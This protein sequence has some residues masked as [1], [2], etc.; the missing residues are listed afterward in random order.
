M[1]L[2]AGTRVALAI[3]ALPLALI[4]LAVTLVVVAATTT[5]GA[6][7]SLAAADQLA[8]GRLALGEVSGSLVGGL[9]L[10]HVVYDSPSLR[11]EV[12]RVVI[13][14]VPSA[15]L[16]RR[17][18]FAVLSVEGARVTLRE[19]A[20]DDSASDD[21]TMLPSIPDWLS[22]RSLR[23][24][25]AE[26]VGIGAV[27]ELDARI[28]GSRIE[29]ARLEARSGTTRIQASGSLSARSGEFSANFETA[30]VVAIDGDE[31]Q[32]GNDAGSELRVD[33]A[34]DLVLAA[35]GR[36]LAATLA[37]RRFAV[38]ASGVQWSSERGEVAATLADDVVTVEELSAE[39]LGGA[40][41]MHGAASTSALSGYA[42]V[43]YERLDPS[44]ASAQLTGRVDGRFVAAF[45]LDPMLVVGLAGDTSG[46]LR[47][48]AFDADLRG[49]LLGDS[50]YLDRGDVRLGDGRMALHGA[51]E[52]DRVAVTFDAELPDLAAWYPEASGSA[53]IS[54]AATGARADPVL[55]A[56]VR[57]ENA[58]FGALPPLTSLAIDVAGT[59]G[60]HE[61]SAA[62]ENA[63]AALTLRVR[64]GWRD[65]R[66][67]GTVH[68]AT[69]SGERIG[70]W[71]TDTVAD[72]SWQGAHAALRS[73]C[74]AGPSAA[75]LCVDFADDTLGVTGNEI[76]AALAAAAFGTD[77]QV[78]G[79]ADLEVMVGFEPTLHG[80]FMLAQPVLG[81]Q[82]PPGHEPSATRF[83]AV[84]GLSMAGT[85][86]EEAL[87]VTM[88]AA[89]AETGGSI[90]GRMTLT[91]PTADGELDAR[92]DA[93]IDDLA[94]FDVL[95]DEIE[96]PQGSVSLDFGAT[97]TPR[98][99][100]VDGKVLVESASAALPDLGIEISDVSLAARADS[101]NGFA[102]DA[103]L[104][105]RGCL[106]V[107]GTLELA[108]ETTGW[109][110][111]AE[112]RGDSF[113]LVDLP[114]VRAVVA[115]ELTLAATPERWLVT[116]D[117]SVDEGVVAIADIPAGAVRPAP[118]TVVHGSPR[119]ATATEPALPFAMDVTVRLGLVRFD[120]LGVAAE[121]DGELDIQRSE[122]G[123][124]TVTGTA[125]I[126]E[127]TF[128]AYGQELAIER[129]ELSFTGPADNPAVDLRAV[130][131]VDNATVGL[132]IMG[133]L[134]NPESQVFSM[135]ALS[136]TEAL[137]RLITGRSLQNAAPA[138]GEAI[139]RAALALGIRR[140]L[141][142]LERLGSR[143]GLDELG[144]DSSGGDSGALVAGRQLGED[145]YL[146][147]KHGL[148]D[149][150]AGLELIYRL[151]E[152]FRL[153]TETGTSQS[154]D[155]IY[156]RNPRRET[157]LEATESPFDTSAPA[158]TQQPASP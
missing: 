97:G 92:I 141:P 128:T 8:P 74:L 22:V 19:G 45:A 64:Q 100:I 104:C 50:A 1:A 127:G 109:S 110:I 136:D 81:L 158:S 76:P 101:A 5:S 98:Q 44:L 54:G 39:A 37:W 103:T 56:I 157:E 151:T 2:R 153:R 46:T 139:E 94:A 42:D 11:A 17:A 73:L 43:A 65:D 105:S 31:S 90:D 18:A 124:L 32:P 102:L 55:D 52:A 132:A 70:S 121:L 115:P 144:V 77:L 106:D 150:F 58:A 120:S 138:D 53:V 89:L 27:T 30:V 29:L 20:N 155:L 6:R 107:A 149:D 67:A 116:G 126:E 108:P 148:F 129:G 80:S 111:A 48:K 26:L 85:L 93:R 34:G 49:R 72:Y 47:G 113:L 96:N 59:L 28:G 145:V 66:L 61:I 63:L 83:A 131:E 40:V 82:T 125:S 117:L 95:I 114:D 78:T 35:R 60:E 75:Q 51:V 25:D 4:V 57:A 140:A 147:Y 41:R 156:E 123:Q 69:L 112:V 122:A 142:A 62:A 23:I 87:T 10:S 137:A 146:R 7:W 14:P 24:A 9:A 21:P 84:E 152:R 86:T 36:D 99:P 135:P 133:T 15:W 119:S 16:E 71:T 88:A 143:L 154:L 118:E 79:A 33:L 91:P 130:R 13:E 12:Q 3:L 134:R 68:A 38:L